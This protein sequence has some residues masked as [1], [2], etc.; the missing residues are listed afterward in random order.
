MTVIHKII[1]LSCKKQ[2][3]KCH[4]FLYVQKVW[5]F[6]M[7]H[8]KCISATIW[9]DD[10]QARHKCI[11]GFLLQ[12]YSEPANVWR[13]MSQGGFSACNVEHLCR[14]S[15]LLM[16][17]SHAE[18]L[19]KSRITCRFMPKCHR[20]IRGKLIIASVCNSQISGCSLC[21]TCFGCVC[22]D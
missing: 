15:N 19:L 13:T 4:Y 9:W 14:T 2:K 18:P 16:M 22:D 7:S 20:L 10:M 21:N 1:I 6:Y 11:V 17:L 3:H 12:N 8:Y 5:D